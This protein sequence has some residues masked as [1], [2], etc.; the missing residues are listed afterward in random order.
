[1]EAQ[2]IFPD[3]ELVSTI[4]GFAYARS[5]QLPEAIPRFESAARQNPEEPQC[6]I[7]L[8]AVRMDNREDGSKAR[9]ACE[10]ALRLAPTNIQALGLKIKLCSDQEDYEAALTCA[11]K[12]REL[13]P[14]NEEH[15]NRIHEIEKKMETAN[16]G[17]KPQ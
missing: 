12:L 17:P 3:T 16:R 9:E 6:W 1:M 15:Q 10:T 13:E 7:N 11:K 8:A 4:L 2:R 14:K 5:G